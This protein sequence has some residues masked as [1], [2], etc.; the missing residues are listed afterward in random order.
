[1]EVSAGIIIKDYSEDGDRYLC[2]RAFSNWDFPK[3]RVEKN[4][5][6]MQA[7]LRELE[8]ET[9]LCIDDIKLLGLVAPIVHYKNK[10]KIAHYFLAERIS[11]LD[12]YLPINPDLGKPE[13]DDFSWLNLSE[14]QQMFPERLKEVLSWLESV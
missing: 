1:M 2:L 10:K 12:P 7:A 8:E 14:M 9:G 3:G 5:T 13:H 4:E 11:D 6:I